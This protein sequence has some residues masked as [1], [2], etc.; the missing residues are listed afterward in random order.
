[1][2]RKNKVTV[3]LLFLSVA[4]MFFCCLIFFS[5][6]LVTV[7]LVI[8]HE[9]HIKQS[10]IEHVLVVSAIA[11]IAAAFRSWL[12]AKIDE[13]KARKSTPSNPE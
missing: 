3:S 6:A 4:Y 2:E 9:V 8:S 11:G 13:R 1:M 7:K 12:F 10:D 5:L